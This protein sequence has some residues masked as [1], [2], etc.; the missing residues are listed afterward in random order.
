MARPVEPRV[1]R[2]GVA[3]V[4][5]GKGRPQPVLVGRRHDRVDLIGHQAMS[6]DLRIDA[7]CRRRDQTAV[8][9]IIL[10]S[11]EH[12]L[13]AIAA[14][15]NMM[16]QARQHHARHSSHAHASNLPGSV[17]GQRRDLVN[18]HRNPTVI[19]KSMLA[20]AYLHPWPQ[21]Y[22]GSAL[23]DLLA[24]RSSLKAP[25]TLFELLAFTRDR[26]STRL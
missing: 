25:R 14:L 10:G 9:P 2:P 12:R 20:E 23:A 18:C 22:I 19:R 17:V 13:T 21:S 16:R 26:K 5:F 7:T 4:R 15:G 3:P 11:E 6:P 24:L 1:D 8:E